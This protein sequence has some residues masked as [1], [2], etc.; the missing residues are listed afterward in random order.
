MW[1]ILGQPVRAE[2]LARGITNP[3]RHAE[4]LA[5][6]VRTLAEAGDADRARRLAADA[7]AIARSVTDPVRQ[8][9]AL[10]GLVRAVAEVGD[11]DRAEAIARGI[12]DPY[13]Q[14]AGV[15]A[16]VHARRSRDHLGRSARRSPERASPG[17]PFGDA[18]PARP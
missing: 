18:G 7:E 11:A 5:A 8:A 3:Y 6:L 4:A 13:Q 17:A 12:T 1:A 14:R 15:D 10:A 16:D 2:S 9:W